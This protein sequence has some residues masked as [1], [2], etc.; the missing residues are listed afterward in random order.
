MGIFKSL[1]SPEKYIKTKARSLPIHECWINTS[2]RDA[3]L[4]SIFISRRQPSGNLIVGIYLVDIKCLGVKDTA[5]FFNQSPLEYKELLEKQMDSLESKECDYVLAHNIIF[6]GLE[7]AAEYKILPHKDFAIS[8]FILEDDE[9]ENVPLM[10]IECGEKG[11]PHLVLMED[12]VAQ[13]TKVL[14]QLRSYPGEGNFRYTILDEDG[15]YND[16]PDEEDETEWDDA[17]L[18]DDFFDKVESGEA[19]I[20]DESIHAVMD[21]MYRKK[22]PEYEVDINEAGEY[23]DTLDITYDSVEVEEGIS[24]FEKGKMKEMFDL[25]EENPEEAV[26]MLAELTQRFPRNKVFANYMNVC[27][28]KCDR[29]DEANAMTEKTYR[30]FPGYIYAHVNYAILLLQSE[31]AAEAKDVMHGPSSLSDFV[32]GRRI[33]YMEALSF[34][35]VWGLYYL[36][37]NDIAKGEF[38]YRVVQWIDSEDV[39]TDILRTGLTKAKTKDIGLTEN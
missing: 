34:F 23:V 13:Y 19:S 12:Q 37:I 20:E 27:L 11:V 2:W 35:F 30:D 33:H 8:K 7:F 26:V 3:G 22:Y 5:Y 39:K 25:G 29:V 32:F 24:Q 17:P 38:Y 10:D 16:S 36:D 4:A 6:A 15:D 1:L 18:P 21:L 31:R 9:D 14:A 28:M